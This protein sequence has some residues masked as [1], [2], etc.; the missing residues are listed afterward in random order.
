MIF[1]TIT[2]V[3][4]VCMY[5]GINHAQGTH[6][7]CNVCGTA[8]IDEGLCP[9]CDFGI[10]PD[11][12]ADAQDINDLEDAGVLL[13]DFN[14][15]AAADAQQEALLDTECYC[16]WEQKCPVC[17]REEQAR[18]AILAVSN[19]TCYCGYQGTCAV[20]EVQLHPTYTVIGVGEGGAWLV[21]EDDLPF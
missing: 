7:C 1:S 3:K 5:C 14:P 15:D 13:S 16:D 17:Y 19:N 2:Y 11:A 12:A 6:C 9:S 20:C 18:A 21:S 10:N 4:G 8:L